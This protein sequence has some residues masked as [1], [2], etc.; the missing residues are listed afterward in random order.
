M[1]KRALALAASLFALCAVLAPRATTRPPNIVV[2]LIDT[3]RRDHLPFHGYAKDTAPFLA[4]L[5][6]R[7]AVFENAY[8]TSSWT[9]P[10]AASLFTSLY[11]FQHGVLR[12]LM[13]A[14]RLTRLSG[15]KV[16]LNR[17]PRAAETLPEALVKRGYRSFAVTE[18]PN[19]SEEMGFDQGFS[20]FT[21]FP[22]SLVADEITAK[23]DELRPQILARQPYFLYIH[24]MDV[25][26][27]YRERPPLFDASLEADARKVSAY[28]SGI[29]TVDAHIRRAWQAFGWDQ[30]LVV[31]TADHGE[32]LGERGQFGHGTSLY[33]ELLDIPLLVSLP[34]DKRQR[35]LAP[36]VS[37]IDIL[38][39]LREAAG[40]ALAPSDEGVSLMALASGRATTLAPRPLFAHLF[41]G[42]G[43]GDR[44][45]AL[46]ATLEGGWKR[47]GGGPEGTLLFDLA[48]DPRDQ[49]S[50][51]R[52]QPKL[53]ATLQRRYQAFEAR[54][55]KYP[56]E[57]REVGLDSEAVL[58]L[59]ALGYV[60]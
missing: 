44:E 35:R 17:L 42:R 8:S 25:H 59:K 49:E 33:A 5:A 45:N 50:L 32:E 1:L 30:A 46:R 51:T 48:R 52:Q 20:S 10:A 11:P 12:G 43:K 29:F 38:P 24:Y 2:I 14:Q 41:R 31:V 36:P 28:D 37:L 19:L 3:L 54:C 26:G 40:L 53:A 23:L 13:L 47:I 56:P 7:S 60:Q 9:P 16:R 34:G 58:N 15:E 21:N 22:K 4:T 27:P 6:A 39:T 57:T 18:N 55:R